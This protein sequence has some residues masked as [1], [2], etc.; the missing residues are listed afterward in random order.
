MKTVMNLR[1]WTLDLRTL[2]PQMVIAGMVNR[3]F[4]CITGGFVGS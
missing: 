2:G 4:R 3:K 1:I